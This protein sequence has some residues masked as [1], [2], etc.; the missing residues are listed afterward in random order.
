[1]ANCKNCSG[2]LPPNSTV[3]PYC[4]TRNDVDLKGI[5]K[6]T[7]EAPE[8]ERICPRCEIPLQTIDLKI[9]GRF[10]IERCDECLGLFFDPGELEALLGKS[11][12][13]V[14]QINM[15]QIGNL[16]K[17]R[18]HDDFPVT[19]IKC[20]ICRKLMNR[21]N[22]GTQSGVIIDRCKADGIWLDGGELRHLMEWT[23][24]GGQ[25]LQ[26]KNKAEQERFK[27]QEEERKKREYAALQQQPGGATGQYG[28]GNHGG[29]G[30]GAFGGD[31]LRGSEYDS[32]V[33]II[34]LV[35]RVIG[36]LF[37]F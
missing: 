34:G 15:E 28:Y 10:L 13:N 26:D 25:K 12:S 14:F 7:V 32:G 24:A 23:K 18:R 8:S 27:H 21:L 19:Y 30:G 31:S 33:D 16:N 1:M 11:V 29:H 6:P 35:S 4:R 2:P 22:Y 20:P 37:R 17:I 5:Y 9:E 3:C 36:G